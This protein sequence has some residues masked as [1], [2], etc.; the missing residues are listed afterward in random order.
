MYGWNYNARMNPVTYV[1]KSL[2]EGKKLSMVKNSSY[3][4]PLY[5]N[6]CCKGIWQ[7]LD[8]KKDRE[9]YHLSGKDRCDRY[10]LALITAEV[11]NLN[12]NLISPVPDIYFSSLAKRPYDTS[13]ITEKAEMELGFN[14]LTLKE[15]LTLMKLEEN[16]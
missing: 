12:K 6:S 10:N 5:I 2:R 1:I 16:K 7:S 4:N 15:G 11:F 13:Y 9:V 14:P 3:I 8:L